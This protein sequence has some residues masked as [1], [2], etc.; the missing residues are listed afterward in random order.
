MNKLSQKERVVSLGIDLLLLLIICAIGFGN[1]YPPV[2]DSGFWFYT[3][4]L[5]VLVG[6][7]IVTPFY[8]KPVDAISYSVPAFV[9]LMLVNSWATWPIET[10]IA[11]F[12]VSALSVSILVFA[13]LAIIFNNWGDEKLQ[14]ISNKIRIFLEVFAK[15][16]IIYTP[17]I[18][19]AMYSYHLGK[20]N[21][22]ILISIAMLLTVATSAGDV[23]V[24][25]FNRIRKTTKIG[26]RISSIA[27]IAAYQQ[28]NIIL[29]RQIKDNDLPLK[30]IVYVKDKYSN[31]KLFLTLD[32]VGRDNGVL[33]RA[34]EIASLQTGQYKELESVVAN[35]SVAVIEDEFLQEICVSEN[36]DLTQRDSVVGI[37][38]PD[39]SI[40]RLFF[41]VVDN[42]NIEEGRLVT[43]IVQN[44]KVLYQIVG[45]LTKEEVVYQKNTYGYLRAQAQQV[46]IWNEE[47]RKFT[48]FSWLPNINAPVYLEA[49]E[50]YVIEPDTIG[51]FPN[52]NY[53]VKIG[54][55]NHLVTHNTAILGILGV[56]KSMLA[57]ELLERMMSKGI[58]VVCLDLT[59]QYSTELS[60]YYN[61]PYEETCL[62][63]LRTAT[64]QDRDAWQENPEH[65]GSLPNLKNAFFEDLEEFINNTDGHVLK[66]YNP[67]EF[68]ATR[69]DRA[70]GSFQS[71]P[72]NWQRGA[73]LF[74]VTPVEI[75]KIVSETVLE[76]LSAEMSD[77]AKVC[78]VYEEA[79]SL[80]PEW[81]SV[82]AEGDKHATSG[83]ARA[84]LQGRKFGLGCLLI[85]QRTANVTK[86]I[87]N[88]CNTIFA[89][90]TFDDTGK[91]FL[92]N[93]IG[94]D[95]A[96]SLSSVKERHAVFFGRGSSCENPILMKV[97]DRDDFRRI[98]RERHRPPV[99]TQVDTIPVPEEQ[100]S[101]H[102]MPF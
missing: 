62:T 9:S 26:Q 14:E 28:P 19:F 12:S 35:D 43:V 17:I 78:L 34:V 38:A 61:A 40:E 89:M 75:T 24:N 83:T 16:Q 96:Q 76:I 101:E 18:I 33:T 22:L 98:Y 100:P 36:I 53:Q 68:V 8:V 37:V 25:T 50:D 94:R 69:Q 11:F 92:G 73:P 85:T 57:I 99:F 66:I 23:I 13:L 82:V 58:K 56:G 64:E 5:S 93:Y 42:S 81:N 70:P 90:R 79:H 91:D 71:T 63:K 88:Q 30:K 3:A 29:L 6:S 4:L 60:S 32:L 51:H 97:N 48:Q 65:G 86:T 55:I 20:P 54:N 95:Y 46:G 72:G 39:S 2:G 1:L 27:E 31:S 45:G 41:E 15:P 52:S 102:D 44:K 7:K 47:R 67:A 80:V 74:S 10:K 87:L 59:D 84:I 21:E 77:N 49:Q